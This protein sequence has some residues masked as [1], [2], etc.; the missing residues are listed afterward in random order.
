[1]DDC[2]CDLSIEAIEAR[3]KFDGSGL[4]MILLYGD[5]LVRKQWTVVLRL[6][7]SYLARP[8]LSVQTLPFSSL[9]RLGFQ[10]FRELITLP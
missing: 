8:F 4:S 7:H 5:S 6:W 3:D 10:F 1:M 2:D 9:K